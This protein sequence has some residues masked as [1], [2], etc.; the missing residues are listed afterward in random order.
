[1]LT[2]EPEG[3]G[4]EPKRSEIE[5]RVEIAHRPKVGDDTLRRDAAQELLNR[6]GVSNEALRTVIVH[7]KKWP[8]LCAKAAHKLER[9]TRSKRDDAHVRIVHLLEGKLDPKKVLRK[10]SMCS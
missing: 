3:R 9:R 6:R 2:H 4:K 7:C 8:E 5:L 10:R 1:M